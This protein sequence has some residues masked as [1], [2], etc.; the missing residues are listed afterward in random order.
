M[1]KTL[2]VLLNSLALAALLF[3]VCLPAAVEAC[4]CGIVLPREGSLDVSQERAIIRWDGQTEDIVM[5]LQVHGSASEAAWIMP[6]PTPAQVQLGDAKM[7]DFLQEFTKPRI[8]YNI[9][10][11]DQTL[12]GA[13]P[14][15]ALPV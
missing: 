3:T 6:V 2:R 10:L 12:T 9:R 15:A 5:S 1:M 13:L 8:V 4:G 7:F 11:G 14:A